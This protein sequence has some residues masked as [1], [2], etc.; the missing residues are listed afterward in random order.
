MRNRL[1]P[2]RIVLIMAPYLFD[3]F[4]ASNREESISPFL[5]PD[6]RK[7]GKNVPLKSALLSAMLLA[8][9]FAT[10]LVQPPA[11]YLL[12]T[13]VYF[14]VG[15]P[16][17]IAALDDLRN[18]EINIDVLMT[19]AALLSVLIG[20]GFEG[21]LLLVLFELS[22]SME[23]AVTKKTR[24]ALLNLNR[25]APR[26]ACVIAED[27]TLF[28][29]AVSEIAIGEQL[30][31][32]AGELVPLD[33]EV[34]AGSS[35]VNLVHL[36]G[37]SHPVPKKP[38]DEVQAGARN[39]DGTLTVKVTRTSSDSTLARI[40][41]LITQAASTKPKLERLLDKFG[42]R[43]A[44]TIMI[45]SV[46]FAALLPVF[47]AL[48]YLGTEGAV[49]RALT[50]LIAASPCALI[51]A[52]PTAYLSAISSCARK[53]ILLKGGVI[54]DALA[55]SSVI[56]F[57]K[58]GT[59]TT[60]K[61][62]CASLLSVFPE[63]AD[64]TRALSIAAALERNAVHPVAE[65][66]CAYAES[67][68][69]PS[70]SLEDFKASAGF[71]LE[72]SIHG[73]PVFIGHPEFILTK[74]PPSKHAEW[75]RVKDQMR[76]EGHLTTL[77]LVGE[78][79]F[80]FHFTDMLRPSLFE[81]LSQLKKH[82]QVVMLTG[83]HV[84]NAHYVAKELGIDEVFANLRPED[85]LTKVEE[86]SKQGGLIMVGDGVNDAPALA[87]ATV[88]ISL[89]KIG[90]M[91]AVDA[92]DIVFLQDDLTLLNW[93]MRKAHQTLA[94]V[95]QNLTLSMGV[96]LLATT[97]AL[98]GIVPLWAAVI[99]HEGGTVLVGLNSLRLLRR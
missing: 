73:Q 15:T 53:G 13:F 89:G 80:A 28:E 99:L 82:L 19:V 84:D 61:L 51:I 66:I 3:E 98:L 44:L 11:G 96:I 42:K 8:I 83:D 69:A 87:R 2:E 48:P 85:K 38:Q 97:P 68:K 91:A 71:G 27:G 78:E 65:A 90:S 75:E 18:L 59:L 7:W 57:D 5:T 21:A 88:G 67:K 29:R 40:I 47:F 23:E 14:L 4:F 70:V 36:T 24:S 10:W 72:G 17:L 16:A 6:S 45:L 93:L 37:E 39:L 1:L 81:V 33:G 55:N 34:V 74:I 77:L 92:S 25:L 49:Y 20:S 86:L 79:L 94:I 41:Q 63:G 26:S 35:F 76:R 43:Y 22:A 64:T 12:L 31:I 30:L 54:L 60:G 52:T 46:G 9:A 62:T 32:K 50:F 56:A 58:T 95:K